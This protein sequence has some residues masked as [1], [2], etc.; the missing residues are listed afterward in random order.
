M[1]MQPTISKEST[2]GD[3]IRINYTST[4]KGS[5][6]IKVQTTC[7]NLKGA[8]DEDFDYIFAKAREIMFAKRDIY[9]AGKDPLENFRQAAIIMRCTPERALE[10]MMMKHLVYILDVIKEIEETKQTQQTIDQV[11]EKIIDVINYLILLRK[12]I[13][14]RRS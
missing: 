12:M 2:T 4:G 5:P 1:C 3:S 6:Y 11:D 7:D 9:T 10:G 13:R 8:T 14:Q